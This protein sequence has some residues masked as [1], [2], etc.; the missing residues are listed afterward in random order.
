M[1][2]GRVER[3]KD[4]FSP[5]LL[6]CGVIIWCPALNVLRHI[7]KEVHDSFELKFVVVY[8]QDVL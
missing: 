6:F 7:S 4:F 5:E 1:E 3:V 2:R 8:I